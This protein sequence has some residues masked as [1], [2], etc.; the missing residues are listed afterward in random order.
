MTRDPAPGS[1]LEAGS[2]LSLGLRLLDH[3]LLGRELEMLGNV[4]DV[5]LEERDG[6]LVATAVLRGPGAW[7]HRQPGAL[8]RWGRAVWR[9]LE[10]AEDPRPLVLPLDHVLAIG[11]AV[12]VDGWAEEYLAASDHAELWLR[13]HLVGRIPGARGGKHRFGGDL[14]PHPRDDTALTLPVGARLLSDLLG[15]AVVRDDGSESGRV[16]EVR[17][18]QDSPRESRVGTLVVT[19]VVHGPRRL[20]GGLGYRDDQ[21]MAPFLLGEALRRWHRHDTESAW[22]QVQSLDWATRRITLS[23]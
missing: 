16:V 17:A 7:S 14:A 15:A 23:A 12:H 21:A 8:G 18:A 6:R 4:D 10:R 3:Q 13:R 20:G 19:S 22:E 5:A 2:P 1:P 9:R 11:S